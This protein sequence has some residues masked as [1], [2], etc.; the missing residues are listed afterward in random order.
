MRDSKNGKDDLRELVEKYEW[1]QK[2]E[3]QLK[4]EILHLNERNRNL[5]Q[6][7]SR[8][9]SQINLYKDKVD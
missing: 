8:K 6:D 7:L 2:Q 9:D 1:L 5:K 4:D 3:K